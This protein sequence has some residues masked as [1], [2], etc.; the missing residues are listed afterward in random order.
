MDSANIVEELEK[1]YPDPPLRLDAP[2]MKQ[3]LQYTRPALGPLLPE[4]MPKVCW[5]LLNQSSKEYF[6]RTRAER[7]G[8]P[9]TEYAKLGGDPAFENA[10]PALRQIGDL[11]RANGGPFLMGKTPCYADFYVLGVIEFWKRMGGGVFDRAT[12]IEPAMATLY[13]AGAPWLARNSH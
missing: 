2:V 5:N 8:M 11:L 10:T 7:F 9:L 1:L 6:E 3:L 13:E 4:M 12:K